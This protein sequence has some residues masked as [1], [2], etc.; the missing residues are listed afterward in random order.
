MPKNNNI[1][2]L[3]SSMKKYISILFLLVL[4]TYAEFAQSQ[5]NPVKSNKYFIISNTKDSIDTDAIFVMENAEQTVSKILKE[6]NFRWD[7]RKSKED[8]ES[9]SK[10]LFELNTIMNSTFRIDYRNLSLYQKILEDIQAKNKGFREDISGEEAKMKELIQELNS[11]ASDST[12]LRL[13]EMNKLRESGTSGLSQLNSKWTRAYS[14]VTQ[15]IDTLTKWKVGVTMNSLVSQNI[16]DKADSLNRE[17]WKRLLSGSPKM[18]A[19]GMHPNNVNIRAEFTKR[20]EAEKQILI[21]Y[22]DN[23]T[24]KILILPLIAAILAFFWI[25]SNRK[26]VKSIQPDLMNP[27]YFPYLYKTWYITPIILVFNFIHLISI[28]APWGYLLLVLML[29]SITTSYML[30]K[31]HGKV[32]SMLVAGNILVLAII[33]FI[34][35]MPPITIQTYIILCLAV[36]EIGI[37]VATIRH[38]QYIYQLPTLMGIIFYVT[39]FISVSSIVICLLNRNSLALMFINT[40]AVGIVQ[41]IGLS[42]FKQTITEVLLLQ[43]IARRLKSGVHKP[44]DGNIL[45]RDLQFPTIIIVIVAWVSMFAYNLNVYSIFSDVFGRLFLKPIA[46]GSVSFSLYGV[47]LFCVIVW[48]ANF[49]QRYIGYF[50]GDTSID[51]DETFKKQRSKMLATKIVILTVGYL[52]AILASGMPLDKIT[53]IIGA[54]GV[55]VG[56]GLQNIV[57]N[58]ISG[59]ILIFDRPLQLGDTVEMKGYS[60]KV[61]EMGIRTS[62]LLSDEGAEIIIPN[63]DI[64]SNSITNWT[65]TDSQRR[66]ILPFK[67]KTEKSKDEIKSIVSTAIKHSDY[68][69]KTKNIEILFDSVKET[70]KEIRILL[71]CDNINKTDLIKSEIRL[72]LFN[73]FKDSNIS[74]L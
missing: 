70:E 39:L 49:I 41:I 40:A 18:H 45:N 67:L 59:I 38:R 53:I 35:N 57:N 30:W 14:M 71:W 2:T 21:Y 33:F 60:G 10:I 61:K 72:L 55:G 9:N 11:I 28:H 52:L 26:K 68:L 29:V 20:S 25:F 47:L 74:I 42:L 37:I 36:V 62:T 17:N 65:H 23:S 15:N 8:F 48:I 27:G 16:E 24:G 50:F 73:A 1:T 6:S 31:N 12:I 46:I 34:S 66:I 63:G 43:L 7:L 56:M 4:S 58:F 13:V 51:E 64:L 22:M 3:H 44:I 54:L 5:T 19:K 69:N 32:I